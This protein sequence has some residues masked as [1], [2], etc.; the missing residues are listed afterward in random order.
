MGCIDDGASTVYLATVRSLS[1]AALLLA[2][3]LAG[4]VLA[5]AY[6]AAMARAVAAKEKAVDT[7]EPA[8]WSEAL[9]LFEEV[10]ALKA[11][12]DSKY[13]LAGAAAKLKEDDVAFEAYEASIGLGLA[14][15]PKEKAQAFVAANGKKVGRVDVRGPAGAQVFVGS[16]LRGT[17][18]RAPMVVFA[19]PAKLRVVAGTKS[20]E[21]PVD[22]KAGETTNVDAAAKLA[23]TEPPPPP[24]DKPPPKPPSPTVPM[25]DEGAGARALGWSL[26]IGGVVV[27]AAGG[28]FVFVSG[29]QLETNRATLAE[30][31]GDWYSKPDSCKKAAADGEAATVQS[32]NDA[33]ATW[34]GIRIAS[35]IGLGTG[36][37]IAAIGTVRLLTAPSPPRVTA[38]LA[39]QVAVLPG[40][41]YFG[42]SGAF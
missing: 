37:T 20:V 14:G 22:V 40:G 42:L 34:S 39:P 25:S 30:K 3:T 29:S 31:C 24:P 41:G 8:A 1:F 5:D 2:A 19:G 33:V 10:D 26:L 13:E 23:N 9:R 28:V 18:P 16:R 36:F 12:K 38:G 32:A 11:T 7:N 6:D 27:G 4:P 15:K 21:I 35:F 17:L